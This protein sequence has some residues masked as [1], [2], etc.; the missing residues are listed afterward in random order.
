MP[1]CWLLLLERSSKEAPDDRAKVRIGSVEQV[2]W[3]PASLLLKLLLESVSGQQS[4]QRKMPNESVT[5]LLKQRSLA[6]NA[7]ESIPTP[8]SGFRRHRG[9]CAERSAFT[10]CRLRH[11]PK[12][13][14]ATE[15]HVMDPVWPQ[16]N[17]WYHKCCVDLPKGGAKN[18]KCCRCM[19]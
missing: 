13:I 15:K 14:W 6:I 1:T 2:T 10:C 12:T 18:F 4:V 5:F 19:T 8:C 11:Q 3:S 7:V 9:S 17:Y 16:C